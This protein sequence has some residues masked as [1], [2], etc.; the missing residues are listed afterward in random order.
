MSLKT[1]KHLTKAEMNERV[2]ILTN[3]IL[4]LKN[5]IRWLDSERSAYASTIRGSL[6]SS[7]IFREWADYPAMEEENWNRIQDAYK[8]NMVLTQSGVKDLL[9]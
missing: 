4:D 1:E 2:T 8:N 3:I 6:P 5:Q 7:P 9:K